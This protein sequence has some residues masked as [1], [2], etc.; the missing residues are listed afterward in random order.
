MLEFS[1][2]RVGRH[3]VNCLEL[4]AGEGWAEWF[5]R[6]CTGSCAVITAGHVASASVRCEKGKSCRFHS[7]RCEGTHVFKCS[8]VRLYICKNPR[9][10]ACSSFHLTDIP[11]CLRTLKSQQRSFTL[12]AARLPPFYYGNLNASSHLKELRLYIHTHTHL[13]STAQ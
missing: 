7:F 3:S 12:S 1:S 10:N 9:F 13:V 2:W 6:A 5:K 8:R 4:Q 11:L